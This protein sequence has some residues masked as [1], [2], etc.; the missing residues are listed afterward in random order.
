MSWKVYKGL[1]LGILS[2]L[3]GPLTA[4]W[5][6]SEQGRGSFQ[7]AS[8]EVDLPLLNLPYVADP[9]T[10]WPMVSVTPAADQQSL[11]WKPVWQTYPTDGLEGLVGFLTS[12]TQPEAQPIQ[13]WSRGNASVRWMIPAFRYD[14]VVGLQI[15][16]AIEPNG[17]QPLA[18]RTTTTQL[19]ATSSVLANGPWGVVEVSQT[20][21]Y[22]IT[23][24]LLTSLGLPVN[25]P[26]NQIRVFGWGGGALPEANNASRPGDVP[27]IPVMVQDNGDGLFNGNDVLVFFAEGPHVWRG[28][29][30]A[31]RMQHILH[32]YAEVARYFITVQGQGMRVA[33]R[34]NNPVGVSTVTTYTDVQFHENELYNLI[35]CGRSWYG[36]K[37]DITTSH[38]IS[39]S[40]PRAVPGASATLVQK[41]VARSTGS[42]TLFATN[43]NGANVLNQ[44]VPAIGGGISPSYAEERTSV[45]NAAAATTMNI[46]VNYNKNG[47]G[48]ATGWLDFVELHVP[49]NLNFSGGMMVVHRLAE[50]IPQVL[51][52]QVASA[53]PISVWEVSKINAIRQLPTQAVAG[54]FAFTASTDSTRSFVIFAGTNFP[55]PLAKGPL[56]N[57]NLHGQ[58]PVD[59]VIV[60]P[61]ALM[62]AAQELAAFH[63][64][65]GLSVQVVDVQHLYN[66][67]SGGV[68]DPTAIRDFMRMLYERAG[69]PDEYPQYLLLMGDASYD[70]KNKIAG[71]VNWVPTWEDPYSLNLAISVVTD[72]YFGF[73]DPTEG[74]N[75]RT[76]L[77]DLG[78]GRLPVADLNEAFEAVGRIKAYASDPG[79]FGTW[80]NKVLYV[81]DDV[82]AGK[83]WETTFI[84]Y[85]ERS[86]L[87]VQ[88]DKPGFNPRKIYTDSYVQELVGGSQ[89]Y[90]KAQEDLF[91]ETDDGALALFYI[92]H[93]GEIGWASERILQLA[94]INSLRNKGALP[95]V[96]TI[97]CEFSR[98]DD[99]NRVSAGEQMFLNP[100]GGAIALISTYRAVFAQPS[101]LQISKQISDTL[102]SLQSN[103]KPQRL[104][105]VVRYVK[106]N[107][108]SSDRPVFGLLGDPALAVNMPVHQAM[109]DSINGVALSVYND[110]LKALSTVRISGHVEDYA[111]MPLTGYQGSIYPVVFDKPAQR[112]TL[113]NDAT[114]VPWP[115]QDEQGA[116]FRGAVPVT[117]GRFEF[118][119]VV[120]LDIN[121]TPGEGRINYFFT[122]GV[123]SGQGG[124]RGFDVGDFDDAAPVDN[125][126]PVV[127][128]FLNDTNFRSGGL[129]HE[130]PVLLAYVADSNGINLTGSGV[131]HD[132][133]AILDGNSA[134]PIILNNFFQSDLGNFRKGVF[135]YPMYGLSPGTHTLKVRVWDTHNNPGE[136]T[137]TFRVADRSNLATAQVMNYP[138][139]F[140]D[141]TYFQV[142][143]NRPDEDLDMEITI[144]NTQGALVQK[145]STTLNGPGTRVAN[146]SWDGTNLNGHPLAAGLYIYKV[147]I[148][149]AT[150]GDVAM[151]NNKLLLLR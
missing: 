143:H 120:P 4:Q 144:Y 77:V 102:L 71:N 133:V 92:G 135:T 83:S 34:A 84:D 9:Q 60:S 2:L 56:A 70:Y 108:Y 55:A 147:R 109:T 45:V 87:R 6:I 74:T 91:R 79:R 72:D 1:F 119:F 67:F 61:D 38:S 11:G 116:L 129:T 54:G 57:Q 146:L 139:P 53:Q 58:A 115:F 90:P 114:G 28:N 39:L 50:P 36:E 118:E 148:T 82:D 105:D 78:I 75:M 127:Q 23:P 137:L 19:F 98:Y 136:A 44:S 29:T 81:T 47:N 104:G 65:D 14:S 85:A 69:T 111:G 52:Y 122:D 140:R 17:L 86:A 124:H 145:M 88:A 123:T 40:F 31:G 46:S 10:G 94:E 33:N 112:F 89:R 25:A 113:M 30:S 43:I 106:N 100:D 80:Q 68:Q 126:A 41:V 5:V 96:V 66:E 107:N 62:P 76:G 35:G 73:L 24:A 131:G 51:T 97:T 117:N 32:P 110:T 130:D 12:H 22:T 132:A 48:P 142:E 7:A 13:E 151:V 18:T 150:D 49:S 42:S 149:S 141:K 15:L 3:C 64:A 8:V 125:D 27:E 99:P 103:G 93:G 95:V 21:L 121:Y 16:A 63:T 101:T 134:N 138:N 20:G 37:F 128:L 26:I 59:M